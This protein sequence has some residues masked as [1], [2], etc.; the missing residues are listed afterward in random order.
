M[1]SKEETELSNQIFY[2]HYCSLSITVPELKQN[3]T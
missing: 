1:K 2:A 3:K